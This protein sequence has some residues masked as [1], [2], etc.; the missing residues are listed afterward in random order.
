MTDI[1]ET[2]VLA[3]LEDPQRAPISDRLRAGMGIVHAM[4]RPGRAKEAIDDARAAGLDDAAIIEASNIGFRFNYL[5][6]VA[7]ALDFDLPTEAAVREVSSMLKTIR[8]VPWSMDSALVEEN[9]TSRAAQVH[10]AREALLNEDTTLP[11]SLRRSIEAFCADLRDAR[12]PAAVVPGSLRRYLT[13]LALRSYSITDEDCAALKKAGYGD[14]A[15]FELTHAG[16]FGA[17][18]AGL[19]SVLG[20]LKAPSTALVSS[21]VPAMAPPLSEE[22]STESQRLAL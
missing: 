1:D 15:I 3:A 6:R 5:N 16:A 8:R 20:A 19:E 7:D 12:R 22:I 21:N 13:K 2:T 18:V 14:D 10:E 17:S 9:G 11:R 4:T